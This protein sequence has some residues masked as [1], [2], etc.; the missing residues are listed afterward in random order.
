MSDHLKILKEEYYNPESGFLSPAKFY[1]NV[2]KHGITMK[3]VK[4]FIES[5]LTAQLSKRQT[6][7]AK[8]PILARPGSYQMDLTFFDALKS[9]NKGYSCVL[10][11]IDNLSRKAYT[12]PW[13]SKSAPSVLAAFKEFL[14]QAKGVK[15]I[16]SDNG[17]E[18]KNREFEKL[19][20]EH[21]ITHRFGP[22]GSHTTMSMVESFNRTI[23]LLL[24]RYMKAHKTNNWV[25][26]LTALTKSYNNSVHSTTGLRPNSV[27]PRQEFWI[28]T[29]ARIDAEPAIKQFEKFHIGD[30]V[31]ALKSQGKFDKGGAQWSNKIYTID[32]IEGWSF[33]LRD[34]EG[35]LA[36]KRYK[37]Y[38][39]QK[40]GKVTDYKP[41]KAKPEA[42]RNLVR[43]KVNALLLKRESIEAA[44]IREKRRVAEPSAK[45]LNAIAYEKPKKK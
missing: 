36:K 10:C 41:E 19:I 2:R 26:G 12:Y 29:Q 6:N 22:A 13:K 32:N 27:T 4:E 15:M 3:E 11:I 43:K 38:E 8:I 35:N 18:F 31:R 7:S 5:Q 1:Q 33:G 28:A 44:N 30:K 23:R 14:K 9:A 21:K 45:F 17:S 24:N 34:S 42:V 20:K 16:T 25:D 39:L 40:I 37:H